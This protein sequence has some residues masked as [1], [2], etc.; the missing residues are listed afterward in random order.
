MSR[1]ETIDGRAGRVG[2]MHDEGRVRT[3]RDLDG[4]LKDG[5]R[6]TTSTGGEGKERENEARDGST[7]GT[8][9]TRVQGRT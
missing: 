4:N 8:L 2:V 5:G 3:A 9:R 6:D 7:E 1:H